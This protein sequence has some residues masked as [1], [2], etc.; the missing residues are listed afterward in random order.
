MHSEKVHVLNKTDRYVNRSEV[1]DSIGRGVHEADSFWPP[2]SDYV[3][4]DCSGVP[5]LFLII[6]H[7][8]ITKFNDY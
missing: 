7:N 3:I 8:F 4:E 5:N 1:H 2:S 6:F